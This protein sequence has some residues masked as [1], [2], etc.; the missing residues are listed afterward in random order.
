MGLYFIEWSK[1]CG[2]PVTEFQWSIGF[3]D[4][5]ASR[6][7]ETPNIDLVTFISDTARNFCESDSAAR[8]KDDRCEIE[9][10]K[11]ECLN[12]FS[13]LS[14]RSYRLRDGSTFRIDFKQG[15]LSSH[16]TSVREQCMQ[17][18]RDSAKQAE[19]KCLDDLNSKQAE[20]RRASPWVCDHFNFKDS[21]CFESFNKIIQDRFKECHLRSGYELMKQLDNF[22]LDM[23]MMPQPLK[24][25]FG[26]RGIWQKDPPLT[27][28]ASCEELGEQDLMQKHNECVTKFEESSLDVRSRF[29]ETK[30]LS[31][32]KYT[33]C[34]QNL[35]K[36]LVMLQSECSDGSE[37]NYKPQGVDYTAEAYKKIQESPIFGMK[38]GS[39]TLVDQSEIIP[40][41]EEMS[42][43]LD[44]KEMVKNGT[45][46]LTDFC[47]QF[48]DQQNKDDCE[49]IT[50]YNKCATKI[51]IA[52]LFWHEIDPANFTEIMAKDLPKTCP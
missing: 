38:Q 50:T 4:C 3:E 2:F 35:Y 47:Y 8:G 20:S 45:K 18:L 23:F 42:F 15:Q 29:Q 52:L 44:E 9:H 34:I 1:K 17:K 24:C 11:I 7:E 27:P 32:I 14:N 26:L 33:I 12:V 13:Y 48:L 19:D 5:S 43:S 10:L 31:A 37:I 30:L 6:V 46:T 51:N 16:C 25:Q 40:V 36:D 28:K 41:Q 39:D 21:D 22:P 49:K